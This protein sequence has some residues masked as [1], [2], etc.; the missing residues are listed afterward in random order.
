MAKA[1]WARSEWSHKKHRS[2]IFKFINWSSNY[3]LSVWRVVTVSIAVILCFACLYW[4]FGGLS[5]SE[6][7]LTSIRYF[8]NV[9]DV[10]EGK[11]SMLSA[12]GLL[13]VSAGLM[14]L[15]IVIAIFTRKF[16]DL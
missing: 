5:A 10:F 8:F 13:E 14:I 16:T 12:I 4:F 6:A 3:G 2:P 15:A 1:S 7:T 11:N 9:S